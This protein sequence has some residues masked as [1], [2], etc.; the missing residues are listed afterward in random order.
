MRMAA[1]RMAA[2]RVAHGWIE[3]TLAACPG[4]LTEIVPMFSDG[5]AHPLGTAVL[6]NDRDPILSGHSAA[7]LTNR[8]AHVHFHSSSHASG[9]PMSA[10]SR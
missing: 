2:L 4:W 8:S 1:V 5:F 3:F 10:A 7:A 9:T 6:A